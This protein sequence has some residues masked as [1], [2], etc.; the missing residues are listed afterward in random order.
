MVIPQRYNDI[1]LYLEGLQ[2]AGLLEGENSKLTFLNC[3]KFWCSHLT[4]LSK[5]KTGEKMYDPTSSSFVDKMDTELFGVYYLKSKD[6]I[7]I[8]GSI[9]A[10]GSQSLV[11]IN[12][13]FVDDLRKKGKYKAKVDEKLSSASGKAYV[14]VLIEPHHTEDNIYQ[15]YQLFRKIQNDERFKNP[16]R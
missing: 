11:M 13:S 3:E 10:Y 6:R 1:R 12:N 4:L 5:S 15:L 2:F 7:W 16:Y 14:K 8:K 9:P